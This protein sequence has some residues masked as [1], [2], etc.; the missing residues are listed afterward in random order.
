MLVVGLRFGLALAIGTCLPGLLV[1]HEAIS[2]KMQRQ[3][4]GASTR[5]PPLWHGLRQ[6]ARRSTPERGARTRIPARL[7]VHC[8][9]R[10]HWDYRLTVTQ[11]V[12]P[13]LI[14]ALTV[15]PTLHLPVSQLRDLR[16]GGRAG[17]GLNLETACCGSDRG[18]MGECM[19]YNLILGFKPI[20]GRHN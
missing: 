18:A 13:A 10:V 20:C 1:V 12:P 7:N 19:R 11:T 6:Q 3:V 4:S 17:E 9:R 16:W 2:T 14:P 8:R 15:T 5:A